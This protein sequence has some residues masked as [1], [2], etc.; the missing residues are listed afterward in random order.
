MEN[1]RF[2]FSKDTSYEVLL[3]KQELDKSLISG[4]L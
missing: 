3:S 1:T 4:S 2:I